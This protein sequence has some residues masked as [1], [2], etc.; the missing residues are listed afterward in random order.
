TVREFRNRIL[1]ASLQYHRDGAGATVDVYA[2]ND[3][4]GRQ[5]LALKVNGKADAG[6]GSDLPTQVLLGHIPMLLR[7]VSRQVLVV[8]LGSGITAAAI[9]QH[10]GT[11]RVDVV[12]IS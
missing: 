3:E 1:D 6:T 7:P 5:H 8:G 10:P 2:W 9:A 12:E 11:E 4:Q